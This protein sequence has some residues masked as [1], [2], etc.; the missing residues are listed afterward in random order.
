GTGHRGPGGYRWRGGEARAPHC[1]GGPPPPRDQSRPPVWRAAFRTFFSAREPGGS[2]TAGVGTSLFAAS[3]GLGAAADGSGANRTT[4]PSG[5]AP[6]IAPSFA[7]RRFLSLR[8][9]PTPHLASPSHAV[10][11]PSGAGDVSA[12][13]VARPTVGT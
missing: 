12:V 11:S 2:A 5:R 8:T 9:L 1:G 13:V 3:A 4:R 10:A 7:A 6:M